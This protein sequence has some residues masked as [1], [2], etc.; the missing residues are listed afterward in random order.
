MFGERLALDLDNAFYDV[1]D[2][3]VNT[4]KDRNDFEG[5]KLETIV[6]LGLDTSIT[7]ADFEKTD[8]QHLAQRLYEE[9]ITN[10]QRKRKDLADTALPVFKNIRESQGQQIQNVAVP[11]SDGRK[12]IQVLSNLDK[13]L[14][15][16][17]AELSNML[18]RSVTLFLID[19]AWKEH[20]RTM[21][22]LKQ[23]VQTAHYEQKDPLVI[24]KGE[25]FNLFSQ[26]NGQVS[27]SI[28]SFLNH[29]ELPVGSGSDKPGPNSSGQG[30]GSQ[31]PKGP[32]L[33]T[34]REVKQGKN[35]YEQNGVPIKPK[36]MPQA[37]IMQPTKTIILIRQHK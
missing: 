8:A 6:N 36:L 35:R 16:S 14:E 5:F 26:M 9:S 7:P 17:G 30:A 3:L 18:E 29:A 27:S 32:K 13:V 21:D 28:V 33:P 19:D 10:Y 22:D 2:G 37:T 31:N 20:L 11:F 34:I 1:A 25:A 23:S 12:G 24:Y 15:S 4:F